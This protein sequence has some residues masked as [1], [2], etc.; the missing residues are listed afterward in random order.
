[1]SNVAWPGE[2]KEQQTREGETRQRVHPPTTFGR[3]SSPS[4]AV[5]M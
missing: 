4:W 2:H 3:Q 5:I 1:M